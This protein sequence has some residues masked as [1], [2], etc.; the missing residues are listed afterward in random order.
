MVRIQ[1]PQ[2]LLQY[3]NFRQDLRTTNT[4]ASKKV[5]LSQLAIKSAIEKE[6]R[7][8]GVLAPT[9]FISNIKWNV[10]K[11]QNSYNGDLVGAMIEISG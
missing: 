6:L 4:T 8:T 5:P 11:D 1:P 10:V 3:P 2:I 9:A 7:A